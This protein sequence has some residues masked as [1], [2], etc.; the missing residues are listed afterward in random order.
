MPYSIPFH[1]TSENSKND[2]VLTITDRPQILDLNRRVIHPVNFRLEIIKTII[3]KNLTR[4]VGAN[5]KKPLT[6]R[7]IEMRFGKMGKV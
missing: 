6:K 5:G 4:N 1:S 2:I 3:N 7:I